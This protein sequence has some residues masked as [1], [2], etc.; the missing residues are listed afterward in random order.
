MVRFALPHVNSNSH[1][2]SVN[3]PSPASAGGANAADV[4]LGGTS[5]GSGSNLDSFFQQF[6][7]SKSINQSSAGS[8]GSLSVKSFRSTAGL[9]NHEGQK[10]LSRMKSLQ[11]PH[12]SKVT[13]VRQSEDE[14]N[15][16]VSGRL[17]VTIMRASGL[18]VPMIRLNRQNPRAYLTY[19]DDEENEYRVKTSCCKSGN[20]KP[21]W[22]NEYKFF[23]SHTGA[24]ELIDSSFKLEVV[25]CTLDRDGDP[26]KG[27][28][29]VIGTG[30]LPL[31]QFLD[32]ENFGQRH[33]ETCYLTDPKS[34]KATGE[35]TIAVKFVPRQD[36][37]MTNPSPRGSHLG[38]GGQASFMAKSEKVSLSTMGVSMGAGLQSQSSGFE[39]TNALALRSGDASDG[40][41]LG[42][43]GAAPPATG[44]PSK[45]SMK[46]RLANMKDELDGDSEKPQD[47]LNQKELALFKVY[48][49]EKRGELSHEQV[50]QADEYPS[51]D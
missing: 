45:I 20:S 29:S 2:T 44:E 36:I 42:D 37:D 12:K 47:E 50:C 39:T 34:F 40:K 4:E 31:Y 3:A 7:R 11:Q 14:V 48:D 10:T 22:G 51:Y 15:T 28:E 17:D 1:G 46:D 25:H 8:S 5:E 23:H 30:F 19:E 26:I 33:I 43:D 35:V 41:E 6:G 49:T 16:N 13:Y 24:A 18:P 32:P 27:E 21:E 38:M 9:E